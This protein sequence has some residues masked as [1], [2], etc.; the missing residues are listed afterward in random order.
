MPHDILIATEAELRRA[1]A[2]DLKAVDAVDRA[3]AAL[4]GG[5]W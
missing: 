3:F 4:A 2:L 5:G 1:V